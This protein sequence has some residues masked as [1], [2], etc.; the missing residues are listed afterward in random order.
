MTALLEDLDYEAD[1]A[2]VA[3]V[4]E[5]YGTVAEGVRARARSHCRFVPPRIHFIPDL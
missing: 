3:G 2:Y 4:L 1:G 5:I